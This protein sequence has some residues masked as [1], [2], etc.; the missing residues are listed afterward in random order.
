[1][2]IKAF[3]A[4]ENENPLDRI[5]EDGGYTAILRTIG[6]VGDSLSSGEFESTMEDG[7]K[8]YHDYY[9]YSWGQ[10]I[11]R[12]AGCTVYNFSRGGM[13]A[14]EYCDSFA[15][16]NGF[17]DKDKACKAYI[18]ALGVNDVLNQGQPFGTFDDICLEDYRKNA[19]TFIGRY[20]EIV[21]RLKEISPD[22]KFFFMTMP[23][24][25]V[26]EPRKSRMIE[27]REVIYK[28]AEFF[29]NSYVID[30]MQYGPKYDAEFKKNFYLGGHLSACGYFLTAKMVASYIDYIIRHNMDDFRQIGFVGTPFRNANYKF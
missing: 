27:H 13:T 20:G 5:V 11:A 14:R 9:D 2:D 1:M 4:N 6:C 21:Q 30:L 24:E 25:D 3:V 22:A 12:M 16:K 17:W 19:N 7:S 29:S 8:G 10:F 18:F 28:M 26:P 15:E 23:D